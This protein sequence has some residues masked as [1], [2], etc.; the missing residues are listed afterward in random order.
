M[1][2]PPAAPQRLIVVGADHKSSTMMLRDRLFLR[3]A[4]LAPFYGRLRGAGF[5]EAMVLSTVDRTE[6]VAVG[7]SGGDAVGEI[8]KLLAAQAGLGRNEI[9]NETYALDGR[10]AVKHV[11]AVACALD[12]L[13]V[14]DTRVHDS[15]RTAY[16]MAFRQGAVG[17]RLGALM[18]RAFA[19][20]EAVDR[21]TEL[22]RRPSSIPGAAVH[23]A[24]DLHGDLARCRALMI[25]GGEMGE[26]LAQALVAAG[27][28][29]LVVTHPSAPRAEA[30]AQTLN[31]HA[32]AYADLPRLLEAADIVL[33]SVNTRHVVLDRDMM[34]RAVAQRRRKP[35]FIIDTGV[36][37]DVDPAV[38]AVEDAFVYT[39]DD[40]E[41]VTRAGARGFEKAV[42]RA[43]ELVGEAALAFEADT[44]PAENVPGKDMP[45]SGTADRAKLESLRRESLRLAGGDADKATRLLVERLMRLKRDN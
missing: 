1:T 32:A 6:V 44:H 43:W 4:A 15:V 10:E 29:H 5:A 22:T 38:A 9:A 41:R 14:G 31:C 42:S 23:V 21:E 26:L 3:E 28:A 19:L 37:G 18:E 11:F 17:P 30:C 13:V 12:S 7:E 16:A 39:L 36:P 25:G 20:A 33:T 35:I 27:L 8:R 2:E 40:L 34:R 45:R 24:R